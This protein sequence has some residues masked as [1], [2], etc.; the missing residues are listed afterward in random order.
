MSPTAEQDQPDE[1]AIIDGITA[2]LPK[3]PSWVQ[4]GPGDDGAVLA[5]GTVLAAD[6]MVQG[7][8]WDARA[9]PEDVGHKLARTNLSDLAAMGAE[10]RW[11]LLTLSLPT[12]VDTQWARDFGRGLAAGL[13]PVPL[14]GGDTTRSPGPIVASLSVGGQLVAEPLLRSG[15]RPE[16]DIWVSGRLGCAALAFFH[17]NPPAALWHSWV[18]PSPP[19]ALG[20]ALARAGLATAAL[21]LS[22]GLAQD[23]ARLCRASGVGAT[24]Q[25]ELLPRSEHADEA[26]RD[27]L[28]QLVGWGEDY[29]LLF[30]AP[31]SHRPQI[32]EVGEAL[33]VQLTRVGRCTEHPEILLFGQP[34]PKSWKHF[35]STPPGPR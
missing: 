2:G 6:C 7:V 9:T 24:V 13:S 1:Q 15:A 35:R 12:P 23:L 28:Y 32:E 3:P 25:P 22:D 10:P 30:T 5:D 29:E 27:T 34:W 33:G 19:L 26:S 17:P 18:R 16:D 21:D 11:A 14:L 4:V 8:H 31:S 20:P